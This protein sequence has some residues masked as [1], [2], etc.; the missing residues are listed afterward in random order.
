MGLAQS[1][2]D[3]MKGTGQNSTSM[4]MMMMEVDEV[5]ADLLDLPL[6]LRYLLCDFASLR[7]THSVCR[8]RKRRRYRFLSF[9]KCGA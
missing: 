6:F 7:E 4:M 3:A 5:V 2:K 8:F 1:R 9:Y